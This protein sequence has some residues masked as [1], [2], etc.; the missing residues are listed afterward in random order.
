MVSMTR[1]PRHCISSI[2][3]IISVIV[4]LVI[5]GSPIL[6]FFVSAEALT[7]ASISRLRGLEVRLTSVC[8]IL[9]F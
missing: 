1:C 3:V 2:L 4:G 8:M 9:L 6:T 5:V 7:L